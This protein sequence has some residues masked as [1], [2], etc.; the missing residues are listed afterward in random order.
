M[1]VRLIL[2]LTL[3]QLFLCAGEQKHKSK[4]AILEISGFKAQQNGETVSFEGHIRNT[5]DAAV[6]QVKLSFV[7]TGIDDKVV[8]RRGGALDA[9][10][11][12]PGEETAFAFEMPWSPSAVWVKIEAKGPKGDEIKL[13]GEGPHRIE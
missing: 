2:C 9:D 10:E 11:L 1:R 4:P 13:S 8:T 12:A 5:S 3:V 7:L 6:R